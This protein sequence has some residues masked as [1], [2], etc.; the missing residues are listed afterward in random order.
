MVGGGQGDAV[1]CRAPEALGSAPLSA[2]RL[3]A[4]TDRLGDD[5]M[6]SMDLTAAEFGGLLHH[7]APWPLLLL[8]SGADECVVDPGTIPVLGRR[9]IQASSSSG[10]SEG[11]GGGR[12]AGAAGEGSAANGVL[13]QHVVIDGAPHNAEGFEDQLVEAIITFLE[14]VKQRQAGSVDQV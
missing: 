6:F 12:K 9:L 5:D 7:L 1:V 3:V 11:V 10:G 2:R 8:Q 14:A 4:L 13:R